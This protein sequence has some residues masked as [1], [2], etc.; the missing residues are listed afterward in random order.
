MARTSVHV[1]MHFLTGPPRRRQLR[2]VHEKRKPVIARARI[3]QLLGGQCNITVVCLT[4]HG[5]FYSPIIAATATDVRGEKEECACKPVRVL[6]IK[7]LCIYI[8]REILEGREKRV[9][10]VYKNE[11]QPTHVCLS[12]LL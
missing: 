7:Y 6:Y 9:Q 4:V 10:A 2:S 8:E 1:S 11:M 3:V 5:L 12:F